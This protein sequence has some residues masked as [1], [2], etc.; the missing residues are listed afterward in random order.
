[1]RIFLSAFLFVGIV[2]FLIIP[3]VVNDGVVGI[4]SIVAMIVGM[5]ALHSSPV[6]SNRGKES[7]VR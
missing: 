4:A 2:A 7:R 5:V 1:M 6:C 3:H